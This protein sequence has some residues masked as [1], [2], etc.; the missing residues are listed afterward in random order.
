MSSAVLGERVHGWE[1]RAATLVFFGNGFGIGAWA[2]SI[3]GFKA[4][5][6]LSD[7]ALS[8]VLLGFAA[9]AVMA[10]PLAG[11]LAPRI[12]TGLLLRFA[13]L[14]FSAALLLP[15]LAG[16]WGA[17]VAAAVVM[18]AAN[19]VQDVSMNGYASVLEQ[20]RGAAIMSSFHAAFSGGGFVGAAVGAAGLPVLVVAACFGLA[21]AAA[22]WPVLRA[23]GVQDDGGPAFVWP[24]RAVL[25]LCAAAALCMMAEGAMTDWSAVTLASVTGAGASMAALGYAGFAGAMF[26][27][28][29]VGDRVVR[30]WGR[31]FVVMAGGGLAMAGFAVVAGAPVAGVGIVGCALVGLGLSNVVPAVFSEAGNLTSSPATGIAMAATVGYAGF[32][33][34]P[35]V[36]GFIATLVGL[37]GGMAFLAVAALAVAGLARR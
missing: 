11:A 25:A 6:G 32:L 14:A 21:V 26:A 19:G 20:R 29:M 7:L 4:G 28:R 33:V 36:I 10:M 24:R 34:G 22:C 31:R 30:R 17:L 9:G 27:G 35:P 8:V 3:P 1:R 5:F 13:T 18:G 37:R 15:G 16:G 23:H 2:A 12:G